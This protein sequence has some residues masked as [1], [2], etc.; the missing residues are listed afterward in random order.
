[1]SKTIC[2]VRSMVPYLLP[3]S[4]LTISG[5]LLMGLLYYPVPFAYESSR[6]QTASLT[7][8]KYWRTLVDGMVSVLMA[9]AMQRHQIDQQYPVQTPRTPRK[10]EADPG[11]LNTSLRLAP[12]IIENS[13]SSRHPVLIRL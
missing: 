6:T 12:L 9:D 13:N 2:N 1:M 7:E 8:Q 11:E 4:L 5:V 3:A 10:N